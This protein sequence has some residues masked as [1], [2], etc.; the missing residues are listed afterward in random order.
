M[1]EIYDKVKMLQTSERKNRF[2]TADRNDLRIRTWR[3][4]RNDRD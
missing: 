4:R 2:Q 1:N 3:L